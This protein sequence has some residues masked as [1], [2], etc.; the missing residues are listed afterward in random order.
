MI[1]KHP[2]PHHHA[3]MAALWTEAFGDS[4]EFVEM[5]FSTG[6]SPS[7]SAV[8]VEDDA[9]V[10]ALYWFD[11]LW[12]GRK[13]A[14]LYA[15]A[16]K[17]ERRG[18]GICNQLMEKTH[19]LLKEKGY[20][21]AILVPAE[22]S[23]FGFYAKMGYTPCCPCHFDRSTPH[24]HFERS[25][26]GVEKSVSPITVAQYRKFQEKLLPE[27]A[28]THTDAAFLYLSCFGEFYKTETGILCK[29]GNAVQEILP[30][31]PG[32]KDS[33]M[34]LPLTADKTL[35]SYFALPLA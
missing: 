11:C 17:K 15:I 32:S 1:I 34:Y 21:G 2:A 28:V 3:G 10:A 5:F 22:D 8:C 31:A 20:H 6:F 25:D 35:P 18:K 23:L 4:R 7:R 13:I 14:Y 16:T 26:S 19:A 33:A 24:C 29:T 12:Q 9:V 30:Y 27:N